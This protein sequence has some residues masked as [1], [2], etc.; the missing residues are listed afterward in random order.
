MRTSVGAVDGLRSALD[1]DIELRV[2]DEAQINSFIERY[3]G[4]DKSAA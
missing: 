4:D 1:R 3:Y 2:A